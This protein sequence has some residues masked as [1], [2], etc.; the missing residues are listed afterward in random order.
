MSGSITIAAGQI[1]RL[2]RGSGEQGMPLD[3]AC[4]LS[5]LQ[6]S[7]SIIDAAEC[8]STSA[9]PYRRAATVISALMRC[10]LAAMKRPSGAAE[11]HRERL[12]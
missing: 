10:T 11:R 12:W 8:R 1:Q 5:M 7:V 4:I 9:K 3:D 6:V 2:G